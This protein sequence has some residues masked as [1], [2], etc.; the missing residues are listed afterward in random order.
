MDSCDYCGEPAT[1]SLGPAGGCAYACAGHEARAIAE[2]VAGAVV[3]LNWLGGNVKRFPEPRKWSIG[4]IE[5]E[6]EYARGQ[7]AARRP[8][9]GRDAYR[10]AYAEAVKDITDLLGASGDLATLGATLAT[11]QSLLDVAR[12]VTAPPISADDLAT[13]AG[14]AK[15][16]TT[17]DAMAARTMVLSASIDENR[18][19]W[20]FATPS[21]KPTPNERAA[22]IGATASLIAAQRAA[23]VLRMMWAKRQEAAVA[24]IL[25]SKGYSQVKR[26][27]IDSFADL[28]TGLFC[29]ESFVFGQKSDVPVGLRNGRYLLLE[30][31]VSGSEV[32]SFKRLNHETVN[33][34]DT[35]ERG[36]AAQAYTGAVLGG[37]F[38]PLNV[39]AAQ[40]RGV[41]IFWEHDLSP[42]G[43]FLDEVG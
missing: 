20:L 22:A 29:P 13:V 43:A 38:R 19:P 8:L 7:Y 23:T 37:V 24:A 34:R 18:F 39:L 11:R 6:A 14:F 33:K 1:V 32:N 15:S 35:W 36:F 42:L 12:Y 21:R 16:T 26:R 2:R 31:K 3:D 41:Y 30:C 28:P 27:R 5:A 25:A 9:E 40:E 10:V 17:G 4:E